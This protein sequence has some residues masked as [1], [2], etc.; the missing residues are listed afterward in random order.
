MA[1]TCSSC[2]CNNLTCGC[3]N[4]YLTTPPPCPTP[5]DCPEKQPCSE[6]FDAECIIYSGPDLQCG[7]E[8]V[9]TQNSSINQ[10]LEDII[11]YFCTA[12][13]LVPVTV[14][15][16]GD[17][18]EVTSETVGTTTTYTVSAIPSVI[19]FVK[20]FDNIFF[21]NETVTILRSEMIACRL[22][23]DSCGVEQT[24]LSDFT[25][26]V[27]YLFDNTWISIT[28]LDGVTLRVNNTTGDITVQLDISPI[29]P[30]VRLR[31]VIIG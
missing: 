7:L 1:T 2:G 30:P 8:N 11:G 9:V 27:Y 21:D 17:N 10:A 12:V 13:S 16:A 31:V 26:G 14:V 4:S 28:N 25:Y 15:E 18:V 19:K 22:L 3:K 20:E 29:D 23:S 5:E 24:E 6:V